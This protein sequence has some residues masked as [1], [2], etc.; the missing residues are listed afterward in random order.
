MEFS[1]VSIVSERDSNIIGIF[2]PIITPPPFDS[3]I[4]NNI[5]LIKLV[6]VMFGPIN[7]SVM[8]AIFESIVLAYAA[9]ADNATSSAIG[10]SIVKRESFLYRSAV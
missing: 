6:A 10:P 9:V 5:L 4:L 3:P 7:M 8:P 2:A 1:F